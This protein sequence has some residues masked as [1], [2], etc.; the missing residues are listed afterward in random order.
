MKT[1][2]CIVYANKY[3]LSKMYLNLKKKKQKKNTMHE[4]KQILSGISGRISKAIYK[5]IT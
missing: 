5:C 1:K 4:N 2:N 3:I